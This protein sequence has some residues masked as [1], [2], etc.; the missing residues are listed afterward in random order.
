MALPL[1][2]ARVPVFARPLKYSHTLT[3]SLSRGGRGVSAVSGFPYPPGTPGLL[4]SQMKMCVLWP[5]A[6]VQ[7]ALPSRGHLQKGGN[8]GWECKKE[9]ELLALL[10][11][12]VALTMRWR[13]MKNLDVGTREEVMWAASAWS[14]LSTWARALTG[15]WLHVKRWNKSVFSVAR[16]EE[17][18]RSEFTF[19]WVQ[20]QEKQK[21]NGKGD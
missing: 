6:F 10:E 18:R 16:Q 13:I 17:R 3:P 12:R 2:L 5:P 4:V 9:K 19:P 21:K 7:S 15:M 1:S 20:S 11:V 14:D 8:Y